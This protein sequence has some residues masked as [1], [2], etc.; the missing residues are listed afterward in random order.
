[1]NEPKATYK[2]KYDNF[3]G[4]DGKLSFH[5]F[6]ISQV[7][8]EDIARILG[9]RA[10]EVK[11]KHRDLK[12]LSDFNDETAGIIFKIVVAYC[13]S[14]PNIQQAISSVKADLEVKIK[15]LQERT[16]AEE[17]LFQ[18][19]EDNTDMLVNFIAACISKGFKQGDRIAPK[20]AVQSGLNEAGP[21][22]SEQPC[23][24]EKMEEI[25]SQF[26]FRRR[27]Q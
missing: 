2:Q 14:H 11:F 16:R 6:D 23:T 9:R 27:N 21:D 19:L 26:E 10:K 4:A 13:N 5:N 7:S 17:R 12:K 25:A 18:W 1:M 3:T 22:D 15:D 8:E 24:V 20:E